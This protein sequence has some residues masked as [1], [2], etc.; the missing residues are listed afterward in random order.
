MVID[1]CPRR[2]KVSVELKTDDID[3]CEC[4]DLDCDGSVVIPGGFNL[5]RERGMDCK[6]GEGGRDCCA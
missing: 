4:C 2:R 3:K 1:P 6:L 5:L